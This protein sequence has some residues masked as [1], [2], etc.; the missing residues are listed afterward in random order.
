LAGWGG[1]HADLCGRG[2]IIED[3]PPVALFAG[4]AA[5]AL[6]H[7][8]EVEKVVWKFLVE[9]GPVGVRRDGLV[10]GKIHLATFD[11][12]AIFDFMPGIAK[13]GKGFVFGV[14]HEDVPV[15]EKKDFGSFDRIVCAVPTGGPEDVTN[16]ERDSGFARAGRHGEKCAL[17]AAKDRIH[18]TVNRHLL[19]IPERTVGIMKQRSKQTLGDLRGNR[20]LPA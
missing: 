18:D 19:V 11:N 9:P 6:I 10:G 7:D 14:V 8:D 2:E 5:V 3:F 13:R 4:A 20:I 17:F 15:G 16:L 1:G 12:F